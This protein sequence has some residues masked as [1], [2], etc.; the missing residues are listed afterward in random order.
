M[1]NNVIMRT[2]AVTDVWQP[3]ASERTICSVTISTPPTNGGTVLFDA[4]GQ[5]V[6][7]VPGE[8]HEFQHIDL[9]TIKIAGNFSDSVTIIGGTW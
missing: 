9:A 1:A 3:L 7:W 6:F 8:W 5:V 4:E 2:V